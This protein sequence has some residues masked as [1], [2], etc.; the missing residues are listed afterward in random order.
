[1]NVWARVVTSPVV[2]VWATTTAIGLKVAN[3]WAQRGATYYNALY[4]SPI[5]YIGIF[6]E[7]LQFF[8]SSLRYMDFL[9]DD[10]L[11]ARLGVEFRDDNPTIIFR[12]PIGFRN[13]RETA[14]ESSLTLE[15][16][17]PNRTRYF[18]EFDLVAGKG[19]QG[20][21]GWFGEAT[22]RLTVTRLHTEGE[23]T[24][25][26]PQLFATV[27]YGDAGY[28][29]Y[30]YGAGAGQAGFNYLSFGLYIISPSRIDSSFPVVELAYHQ[31]LGPRKNGSL[32][33]DRPTGFFVLWRFAA[34]L[35]QVD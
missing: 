26:Q 16:F 19:F 7:R 28:N 34:S 23:G 18:A 32:V 11:R 15:W 12:E 3:L 5:V 1:M 24:L 4:V 2:M 35:F 10:T 21:I 14:L 20:H 22:L 31:T 27:G 13:S 29:L 33:V 8:G 6:N 9:V 25:I 17:I 30:Q